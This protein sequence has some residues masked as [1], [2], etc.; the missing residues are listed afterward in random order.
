MLEKAGYPSTEMTLRRVSSF[1]GR[2]IPFVKTINA[3]GAAA[4]SLVVLL[5][6]I[7]VFM[8]Y[9]LNRPIKGTVELVEFGMVLII[10]LGGAYCQLTK[11]HVGI[12][13]ILTRL[14][15]RG[16]VMVNIVTYGLY[17][18]ILGLIIQ[19]SIPE[20]VYLVQVH[21]LS[22]MLKVPIV[23][24]A[25]IVP[26][27]CIMLLILVLR[28]FLDYI[29]EGLKLQV[30]KALWL[31]LTGIFIVLFA[32]LALWGTFPLWK[33]T[34]VMAGLV[35]IIIMLVFFFTGMPV[36]F[37]LAMV[38]F[39]GLAHLSGLTASFHIL[40]VTFY[41]TVA[42]Y[43]WSCI[44]FFVI[45]GFL[46]FY[47]SFSADLYTAAYKWVGHLPGGL[48][49]ATV[50][51]C[52]AFAAVT[53]DV[54]AAT[55]AMGAVALPEM[56]RYK[57]SDTLA[58]GVIAAGGTLGP[59]IPPSIIFIIYALLTEQSIGQLFIA[60]IMPG[61]LLVVL[62]MVQIYISCR[63]NPMMGPPGEKA[64]WG[65]RVTSLKAVGPIIV[66]FLLVIGG[67]YGGLFTPTEAGAIGAVGA[68]IIGL[69]MK[70]F[71]RK[72]LV[73]SLL[74]TGRTSSMSFFVLC[75]AMVFSY[76]LGASKLT[77]TIANYI[78]SIAMPPIFVI[79]AMLVVLLI[80]GCFMSAL[81]MI[82]ITV[83]IF[84]PVV[85]SLGFDMI[86]F[87]VLITLMTNLGN[88]TPPY[89]ISLFVLTITA[90]V[91]IGVLFKGVIPFVVTNLVGVAIIVAFPQIAIW[92]PNVLKLQ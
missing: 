64:S 30:G 25:A 18:C 36:A 26:F 87:G 76:F 32:L 5:T 77:P 3:I 91:P 28:D 60:G 85:A 13:L 73:D 34:P 33:M 59:L 46:C 14:S 58:T 23:W 49:M 6:F 11:A 27:G 88:I 50:V 90:K 7:D 79:I 16:Q 43:Q 92:L 24:I 41:T 48:A 54:I 45:M 68:L 63:R 78:A 86:W 17:I 70:R 15:S 22:S 12:D 80:L 51:A 71:N 21:Q 84:A 65:E 72:K 74:D 52:A 2:T 69:V 39:L 9:V 38:G 31:S 61:I 19:Q 20:C 1:L 57:Y 37:V 67:I 66:I 62:W 53:G 42:N 56:R 75:G 55:L 82:M 10:F 89:G 8:R 83:P 35:G 4:I 40:G 44:P 47:A 81:A 29:A